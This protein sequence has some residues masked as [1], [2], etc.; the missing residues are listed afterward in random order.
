[1]TALV[2]GA[3]GFVGS[4]ICRALVADGQAVRALVRPGSDRQN[5]DAVDIE[6]IEGDITSAESLLS[7]VSGCRYVF[8]AAADYRLWTP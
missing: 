8:H 1:M 3:N 6:V 2:T 7:A 5:L 4:A